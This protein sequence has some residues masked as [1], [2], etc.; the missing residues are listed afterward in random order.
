MARVLDGCAAGEVEPHHALWRLTS[1]AHALAE[2]RSP[3]A[4]D[5]ARFE[6]DC[7]LPRAAGSPAPPALDDAL[8]VHPATLVRKPPR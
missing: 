2:A 5:G 7:L 8:L 1:A 4:L 3:I 6:L